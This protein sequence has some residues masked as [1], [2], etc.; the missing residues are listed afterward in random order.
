VRLAGGVPEELGG[1]HVRSAMR[2]VCQYVPCHDRWIALSL[3]RSGN[4]HPVCASCSEMSSSARWTTRAE[5]PEENAP[6]PAVAAAGAESQVPRQRGRFSMMTV[7]ELHAK[8]LAVVGLAT[9][10]DDRR[11]LSGSGARRAAQG[12]TNVHF[13]PAAHR[14]EPGCR[15]RVRR[16]PRLPRPRPPRSPASPPAAPSGLRPGGGGPP[17]ARSSGASSPA[18]AARFAHTGPAA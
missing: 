2:T 4:G 6:E 16:R 18:C 10:S 13:N 15:R 17:P 8:S 5:P 1:I 14:A 9:G 7:E 3:G 11:Y 12:W